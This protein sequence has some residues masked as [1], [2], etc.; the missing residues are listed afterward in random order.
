MPK[1]ERGAQT[2]GGKRAA[3]AQTR[4]DRAEA[5][6]AARPRRKDSEG[7]QFQGDT[8][9][10][11]AYDAKP[12]LDDKNNVVGKEPGL[13]IEFRGGRTK[14]YYPDRY[15]DDAEYVERMDAWI[16]SGDRTVE[17]Y[18]ISR[19]EPDAPKLP[20]EI[21]RWDTTAPKRLKDV[22]ELLLSS[23][24]ETAK[25]QVAACVLYEQESLARE[26]VLEMLNG[27]VTEGEVVD[28]LDAEIPVA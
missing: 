12:I 8:D 13:F 11:W 26:D 4:A 3:K 18:H 21:G 27:L 22:L 7:V 9:H 24:E 19:V 2:A 1:V 23:D 25:E 28:A 17:K 16:A 10:L 5:V 15:K 14:T 6:V 20:F